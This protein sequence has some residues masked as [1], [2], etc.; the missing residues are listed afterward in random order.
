MFHRMPERWRLKVTKGHLGPAG[1]WFI[2]DAVIGKIPIMTSSVVEEA[3]IENDRV[4]LQISTGESGSQRM[5]FDHVIAA[6]G[7]RI[8]LDRVN[9]LDESLRVRIDHV[10]RTPILSSNFESSVPGLFFVGPVAANSFGP[11]QRFAVGAKFTARRVSR[12]LAR[13]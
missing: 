1:G 7:F 6:T 8:D 11:V 12:R 5:T 3:V 2:K 9:F 4:R 10:E 13:V